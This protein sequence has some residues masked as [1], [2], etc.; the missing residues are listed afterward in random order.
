MLLFAKFDGRQGDHL[1]KLETRPESQL[2][3]KVEGRQGDHLHKLE[4]RPESQQRSERRLRHFLEFSEMAKKLFI[5]F[6]VSQ[7]LT[8]KSDIYFSSY[9][10]SKKS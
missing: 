8:A 10:C 2:F 3:A 5:S 9:I 6:R 1:Q 4:T 7:A